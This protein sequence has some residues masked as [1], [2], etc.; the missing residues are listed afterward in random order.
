MST[1]ATIRGQ[2]TMDWSKIPTNPLDLLIWIV[3]GVVGALLFIPKWLKENKV[4]SGIIDR[5]SRELAEERQLRKEV[6]A[7]ADRFAA[8]RNELILQFSD[9]KR[10]SA[11]VQQKLDQ[12][13]A[14]NEA[15]AKQNAALAETNRNLS[16][17]VDQLSQELQ[18]LVNAGK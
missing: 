13:L 16:N 2:D 1:A 15:L 10:D 12:V 14:Q 4:E 17:K 8:E 9:M 7:R 6:E 3:V 18:G 5:L 11:L